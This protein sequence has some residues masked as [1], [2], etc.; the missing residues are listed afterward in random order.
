M[1]FCGFSFSDDQIIDSHTKPKN[2]YIN[3][4]N[5]VKSFSNLKA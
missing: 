4:L 5:L 2:D 1:H 3:L